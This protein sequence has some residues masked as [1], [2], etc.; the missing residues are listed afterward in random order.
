VSFKHVMEALGA[1][2]DDLDRLDDLARAAL[3]EG[4]EEIALGPL[5]RAAE[6]TQEALLWQWVGLLNRSLDQHEIAISAFARAS[7]LAPRDAAI[8]H[9]HARVTLE[10]GLDATELFLLAR[11]LAPTDGNVLLGLAAART[12]VGQGAIAAKELQAALDRSPDWTDGYQPLAQLLSTLGQKDKAAEALEAALVRFPRNLAL[13]TTLLAMDVRR[14]DYAGLDRDVRRAAAAGIDAD[15]LALYRAILAAELDEETFPPALFDGAPGSI[16]PML[17]VWQVRHLLRAGAVDAALPLIDRALKSHNAA[18]FWPYASVA[19]RLSLDPRSQWLEGDPSLV[20]I[21]DLT[22]EL[23]SPG[24]IADFLRSLHVAKGEYLDQSVRGGTQTDGP[25]LTRIDPI[26]RDLRSAIVRA[27]ENYL[28]RLPKHDPDH[29]LLSHCRDQQV[30][31]AGSW[32]VRLRSGGHHL[33]HVHPHGWISSALYIALPPEPANPGTNAGW[34]TL[35]A[36]PNDLR[37]ALAPWRA[38]K[39]QPLKLVLFP[40][41]VWH[42]T[43]P[44][45]E[46]ERLTVAFDVRPPINKSFVDK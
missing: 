21:S 43:T 31:F 26:I 1:G 29:P 19:W 9:G 13:W 5:T 3:A 46:G 39:P 35:G 32:S 11:A 33:S 40:S 15:S 20:Q 36:P 12:A 30:R 28:A 25:L 7:Q 8:A 34:L 22:S 27:V 17:Q 2:G 14:E 16:R 18:A 45:P 37:T 42:G 44:T 24:E 6:R 4:E 10:A 38:V 41:W 23:P